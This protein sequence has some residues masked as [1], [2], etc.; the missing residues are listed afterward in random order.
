MGWR[1]AG[2]NGSFP[3]LINTILFLFQDM[4]NTRT[5][6]TII[7]LLDVPTCQEVRV[8]CDVYTHC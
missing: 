2:N 4:E 6:S 5:V 3:V 1:F 8:Y 7:T